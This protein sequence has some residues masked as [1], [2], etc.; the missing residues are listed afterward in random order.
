MDI[1]YLDFAKAFDKVPH[2]RLIGK[3][4]AMGVDGRAPAQPGFLFGGGHPADATELASAVHTFEDGAGSW[5]YVSVP[6]VGKV[7]GGAPERNKK[8]KII[9]KITFGGSVFV[10]NSQ[11]QI[12]WC[13]IH[14]CSLGKMCFILMNVHN[15]LIN[16]IRQLRWQ[17]LHLYSHVVS[18]CSTS[19][20]LLSSFFIKH[21]ILPPSFSLF[22]SICLSLSLYFCGAPP[23][24]L[25][26]F[27]AVWRCWRFLLAIQTYLQ[28]D[29]YIHYPVNPST[30]T[31]FTLV[32]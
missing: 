26:P 1:I 15:E 18:N 4:A 10:N 2:H 5:G 11:P 14:T 8:G 7:M 31:I 12:H 20:S 23:R 13:D 3:V 6:A 32:Q 27:P 19:I 25:I 21:C 28:L 9:G 30:V 22:L 16:G 29:V 17:H 24:F